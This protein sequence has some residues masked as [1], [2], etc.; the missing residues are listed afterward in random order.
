[1]GFLSVSIPVEYFEHKAI[2]FR[3]RGKEISDEGSL[4]KI[5]TI[6]NSVSSL[7]YG[8]IKQMST[9]HSGLNEQVYFVTG[10]IFKI[11]GKFLVR[12]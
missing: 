6:T 10:T 5:L 12:F 7:P 11:F 2:V 4:V 3:T 9:Y 1:M 8:N